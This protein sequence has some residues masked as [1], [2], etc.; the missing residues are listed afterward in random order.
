[1]DLIHAPEVEVGRI[2]NFKNW[3]PSMVADPKKTCLGMEYFLFMTDEMWSKPDAELI[4]MATKEVS[5]LA[6]AARG[7]GGWEGQSRAEDLSHL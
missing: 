4:R 3:S 6:S 7:R 2:Q 5:A 1:L